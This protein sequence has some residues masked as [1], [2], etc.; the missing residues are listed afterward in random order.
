MQV[1]GNAAALLFL[2]QQGCFQGLGLGVL[3]LAA[4][5][6]LDRFDPVSGVIQAWGDLNDPAEAGRMIVDCNLNQPLLYRAT[7]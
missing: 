2:G 7:A 4:Q 6:L 3:P 5:F 1:A